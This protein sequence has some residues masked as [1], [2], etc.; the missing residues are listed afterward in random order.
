MKIM[1][2]L[3]G[4]LA[5]L[6][7]LWVTASGI[8]WTSGYRV[9]PWNAY[10]NCGYSKPQ[11]LPT[12]VRIG[13]Y[14]EFP[15][16]SR[17]RQ[18]R[19]VPFP[20]TLA[21]AA[22]SRSEFLELRTRIMRE[23]SQVRDVYFWPLLSKDEGYYPGTWSSPDGVERIAREATDLPVLWDMEM[24]LKRLP[25]SPANTFTNRTF[26]NSWFLGRKQPVHI[27]RTHTTMGLDPLF[28]RLAGMHF[29]P[30]DYPEI[31]LHL[32]L[33]MRDTA[34]PEAQ[35]SRILRCGVE[36][37]GERFIPS[38]GMLDDGQGQKGEFVSPAILRHNLILAREAGVSQIWLFGVNGMNKS[39]V[40]IL[41]ETIPL[42]K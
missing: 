38:F 29:D 16:E 42:E 8:E 22:S 10:G 41:R 31:S 39:V 14:E 20:V 25:S 11:T 37:Y 7:F 26:L 19:F 35:T 9:L 17:L 12:T 2:R 6:M 34:P 3:T 1:R 21:V 33:Y 4:L 40:D 23:Y 36:R 30:L 18:L 15:V 32:D 24:P 5:A 27:W 28:L 13:L